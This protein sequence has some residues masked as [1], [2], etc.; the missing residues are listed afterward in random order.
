MLQSFQKFLRTDR[1][2]L[3]CVILEKKWTQNWRF[4]PKADFFENLFY[5]TLFSYYALLCFKVSENLLERIL[6]FHNF[7]GIIVQKVPFC[8]KREVFWKLFSCDFCLSIMVYY[9]AKFQL[10]RPDPEILAC[11]HFGQ[12][13]VQNCH[14]AQKSN[15]LKTSRM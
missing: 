11:V 4:T 8:H 2:I 14:C 15:F 12:N 6:R 3:A 13:M 1:E 9:A 10:V 5:V 7:L